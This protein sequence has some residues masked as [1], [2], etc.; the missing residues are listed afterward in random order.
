MRNT[1]TRHQFIIQ[2]RQTETP[3]DGAIRFLNRHSGQAVRPFISDISVVP[4]NPMPGDLMNPACLEEGF[5]EVLVLDRLPVAVAPAI[6]LPF[7]DVLR[8]SF[9]EVFGI[10]VDMDDAGF[11]DHEKRGDCSS[12][13]HAVV[14][15]TEFKPR[16]FSA[17]TTVAQDGSPAAGARIAGAR[18]INENDYCLHGLPHFYW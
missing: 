15:C 7:V 9:L 3:S 14:C 4:L 16:D 10:G 12:H 11:L 18:S 17:V 8:H 13:F 2:K 6:F 1:I 5:P